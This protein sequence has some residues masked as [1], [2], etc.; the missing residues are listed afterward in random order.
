MAVG[1]A[2]S[3]RGAEIDV[4]KVR[5]SAYVFFFR[6]EGAFAGVP[7]LYRRADRE[8][9]RG[10]LYALAV[11][12]GE[13]YPVTTDQLLAL[14]AIPSDRWVDV[15]ALP[16]DAA[17]LDIESM[18]EKGL[19]ITDR[20]DDRSSELR[21]RESALAAVGW[22]VYPALY[23]F[24]TR[25]RGV[26]ATLYGIR[27]PAVEQYV[28]DYG[29]P[30]PAFSRRSDA[31]SVH[32]LPPSQREHPLY[33]LL[34][35]R[36]TVRG[37]DETRP[38]LL[39]D[40][41]ALLFHVFAARGVTRVLGVVDAVKKTSPSGGALHPVEVYLLV[42]SVS[43][44]APGLYHYRT[45]EHSVELLEELSGGDVRSLANQFMQGQSWF[46]GAHVVFVL[47]ARFDR[48][49][50]KYRGQARSY[51]VM[52]MDAAHLSQ[53]MYL[54]ATELG[55]GAFVTAAINNGDIDERLGLDPVREGAI[56]ICGA[57]LPAQSPMDPEFEPLSI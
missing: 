11:L 57:G 26:D 29:K 2:T 52:L 40:L 9:A 30:P 22:N 31:R 25:W 28:D 35:D 55:L 43:G 8:V 15:D 36:R 21:E 24:M 48:H 4:V 44:L 10:Q 56:A 34:A 49:L 47:T 38:M 13:E 3:H 16:P 51:A 14:L 45:D 5:R 46:S 17:P 37:W 7:A 41:A 32:R 50:W 6:Q 18:V 27:T 1:C 19:V 20:D 33:R 12:T 42:R 53:T 23:H 54:V 39:A